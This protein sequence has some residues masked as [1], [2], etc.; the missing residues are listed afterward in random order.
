M[1]DLPRHVRPV[2]NKKGQIAAFECD[3]VFPV[4]NGLL[5]REGAT[6]NWTDPPKQ[7]LIK[8]RMFAALRRKEPP[9]DS[10]DGDV[11]RAATFP[12]GA[13]FY[14]EEGY[15]DQEALT[16]APDDYDPEEDV[17]EAS[18]DLL[19]Q[20]LVDAFDDEGFERN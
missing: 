2:K 12:A 10:R 15:V 19:D 16:P 1:R 20:A 7:Y 18:A 4:P 3:P 14:G 13:R 9:D 5:V 6:W 8:A 17:E 11:R